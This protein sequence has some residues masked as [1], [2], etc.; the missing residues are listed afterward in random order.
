MLVKYV[1]QS[2]RWSGCIRRC[3]LFCA[4]ACAGERLKETPDSPQHPTSS[5]HTARS[6][7]HT[8]RSVQPK[9]AKAVFVGHCNCEPPATWHA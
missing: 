8:A 7:Q 9:G 4:G 5:T 6:V 3:L 2:A 1:Q